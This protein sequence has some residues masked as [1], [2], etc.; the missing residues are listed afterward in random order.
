MSSERGAGGASTADVLDRPVAAIERE[1]Q[2]PAQC[3]EPG[4]VAAVDELHYLGDGVT[5]FSGRIAWLAQL[6]GMLREMPWIRAVM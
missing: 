6:R 1:E 2:R 4:A 5:D 3:V